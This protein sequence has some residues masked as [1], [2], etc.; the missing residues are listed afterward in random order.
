[1]SERTER[2]EAGTGAHR[3][4]VCVA[5]PLLRRPLR[6]LAGARAPLVSGDRRLHGRNV[7]AAARPRRL[8]ALLAWNSAAHVLWSPFV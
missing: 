2:G 4:C 6:R 7:R 3:A 8:A 5:Y 1:M